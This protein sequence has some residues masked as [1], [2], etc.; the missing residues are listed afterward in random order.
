[1]TEKILTQFKRQVSSLELIPSDGGRFEVEVDGK[2]V[3]SK[4][5]EKKFPEFSEVKK[6]IEKKL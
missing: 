3:F 2:L 5:S 6:H 1:M 4:L